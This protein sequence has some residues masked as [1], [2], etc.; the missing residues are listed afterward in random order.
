MVYQIWTNTSYSSTSF[1]IDTAT[2]GNDA[3]DIFLLRYFC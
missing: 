3:V 2:S 1:S